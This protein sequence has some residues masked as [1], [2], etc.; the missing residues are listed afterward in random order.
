M[1]ID[2]KVEV[3]ASKVLATCRMEELVGRKG[4][5]VEVNYNKHGI[6][7]GCWIELEGEPFLDEQEWFLPTETIKK[8]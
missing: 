2:D 3:I 1:K 7:N 6:V 8:I 4:V 5:V